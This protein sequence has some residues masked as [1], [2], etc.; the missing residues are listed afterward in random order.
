[1]LPASP[2]A[3][4][5]SS[6]PGHARAARD[7]TLLRT[8][9]RTAHRLAPRRGPDHAKLAFLAAEDAHSTSTGVNYFGMLR[10]LFANLRAGKTRRWRTITQ[11]VV[12]NVCRARRT[13]RRKISRNDPR[14]RLEQYL[15]KDE[16]L[17][18][19]LN[20]IYPGTAATHRRASRY[21]FGKKAKQLT[22]PEAALLAGVVAAPER[23]H[24]ATTVSARR[25]AALLL[26]KCSRRASSR[27]LH[28]DSTAAPCAW[29]GGGAESELAP[30]VISHVEKVLGEVA[31][32]RRG[33]RVRRD[34]DARTVDASAARKAVRDNL[35]RY[36]ERQKLT[37]PL[38]AEKRRLWGAPFEGRPTR[39]E[40]IR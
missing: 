10:A 34:H 11:Q 4:G 24:R 6:P 32:G 20:H 3:H 36:T 17:R 40:R 18:V 31:G 1:M 21:Y 30:E 26:A 25:S 37:P 19:Y 9:P 7:G 12:K 23:F 22:V 2:S 38:T 8:C 35:A 29:P 16:I 15:S 27:T 33:R 13:Y 5:L 39:R 28:A 14:P